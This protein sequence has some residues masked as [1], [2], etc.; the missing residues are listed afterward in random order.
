MNYDRINDICARLEAKGFASTNVVFGIGSF[1]YQ[2][3]TRDT[4]GFA[5]KATNV[6]IE[7]TEKAIFKD[8]KTDSGLKRSLRGRITVVND[9]GVLRAYDDADA[10]VR[11]EVA[12][13][14]SD[15]LRT[16][17]KNGEFVKELTFD[18]V[19]ANAGH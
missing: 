4:F 8:P 10:D 18:E 7:G 15:L 12:E 13:T 1:N 3:Q 14:G 9:E 16:V 5:M 6:V 2:Y 11:D 19:R 17:W